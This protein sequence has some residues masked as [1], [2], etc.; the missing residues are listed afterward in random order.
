MLTFVLDRSKWLCGKMKDKEV[1]GKT[2]ANTEMWDENKQRGCC[3]GNIALACGMTKAELTNTSLPS[4]LEEFPNVLSFLQKEDNNIN[5]N[6][7]REEYYSEVNDHKFLTQ[8][9]RETQLRQLFKEDGI[10]VK[11]VGRLNK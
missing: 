7:K 8:R 6:R 11:F 9:E 2:S 1:K 4:T 10:T 3:L 5:N